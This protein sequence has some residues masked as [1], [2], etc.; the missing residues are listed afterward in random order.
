MGIL[1]IGYYDFLEGKLLERK[2]TQ[3]PSAG[4]APPVKAFGS[5]FASP[6]LFT[7]PPSR[8]GIFPSPG[9]DLHACPWS[10]LSEQT[11]FTH[12]FAAHFHSHSGFAQTLSHPL[13]SHSVLHFGGAQMVLQ[14]WQSS[15]EHKLCGQT[16]AQLGF[17]HLRLHLPMS[18][19]WHCVLHLGGAQTGSQEL[20]QFACA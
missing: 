11:G 5:S 10:H 3:A 7:V 8:I 16:T 9:C 15:P 1:I 13:P 20:S 18:R 2:K 12:S 14:S 6:S 19:A 4:A 17:S